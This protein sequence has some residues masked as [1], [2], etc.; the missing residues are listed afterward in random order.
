MLWTNFEQIQ[1]NVRCVCV[2]AVGIKN[3]K[4]ILSQRS[5]AYFHSQLTVSACKHTTVKYISHNWPV[6]EQSQNSDRLLRYICQRYFGRNITL[7]RLAN[8]CLLRPT[9]VVDRYFEW[10]IFFCNF[11]SIFPVQCRVLVLFPL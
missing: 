1:T 8:T 5:K 10:P 7:E 3:V 9:V 11:W 6:M 2:W 4:G